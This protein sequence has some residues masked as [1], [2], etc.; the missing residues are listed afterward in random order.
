MTNYVTFDQAIEKHNEIIKKSGGK[1]GIDNAELIK[2]PLEFVRDESYYPEFID[3]LTHLMFSINKNHGFIDGNK[4][5]SIAVS[6]YFLEINF[7]DQLTIDLFIKESENL[8]LLVAQNYMKKDLLKEVLRDIIYDNEL[9][10]R[11][12][13]KYASIQI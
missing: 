9:S 13:A 3:K 4:R 10:D 2:S 8:A 12:R 5:S 1:M 6:A 11:T 7:F